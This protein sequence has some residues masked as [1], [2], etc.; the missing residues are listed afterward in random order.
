MKPVKSATQPCPCKLDNFLIHCEHNNRKPG[1]G[2]VLEIVAT[3]RKSLKDEEILGTDDINVTVERSY[4]Y[5]GKDT[6]TAVL[7]VTGACQP[8]IKFSGG[9][10]QAGTGASEDFECVPVFTPD[11]KKRAPRRIR[12]AEPIEYT[13]EGKTVAGSKAYTVEQYPCDKLGLTVKGTELDKP[14]QSLNKSLEEWGETYFSWSP[15]SLKPKITP[16]SGSFKLEHYWEENSSDWRVYFVRSAEAG[17]DPLGGISLT[18][19]VSLAACLGAAVGVPPVVSKFAGKH[20][21]DILARCTLAILL[22][23]LGT[24]RSKTFTTGAEETDGK[25]AL[26]TEGSFAVGLEA[27]AG[28]D[29]IISIAIGAEGKVT[30]AADCELKVDYQKVSYQ[31]SI[32]LKPIELSVTVQTRAFYIFS[33]KKSKIWKLWKQDVEIWT[34]SETT[35]LQLS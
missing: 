2:N 24:F 25:L 5:S 30:I 28:S 15:A 14:I 9:A 6:V 17:A 13:V 19:E 11:E 26:T 34:G 29:Y 12:D 10:W 18:V 23:L 31:E 27:R 8:E 3:P 33:R 4:D 20:L 22:K 32:K 1:S 7:Q 16:P 21:A 35:L